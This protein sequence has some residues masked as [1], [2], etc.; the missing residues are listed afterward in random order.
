MTNRIL[1]FHTLERKEVDAYS[2]KI[3]I[4]RSVEMSYI[5]LLQLINTG[6]NRTPDQRF[7]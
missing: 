1:D 7:E 4:E 2:D 5:I 3:A 6:A